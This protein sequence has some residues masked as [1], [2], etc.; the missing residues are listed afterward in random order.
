MKR[1][2]LEWHE[3][4]SDLLLLLGHGTGFCK[5]VW[6]PVVTCLQKQAVGATA[7]AWDA[8]GH[9]SARTL[10]TPIDWWTFGR[11]LAVLVDRLPLQGPVVGVGH[12]MGGTTI[13]M[14]DL[15]RPGLQAGMVLVEPVIFPPPYQRYEDFPLALRTARRRSL[16]PSLEAA[17]ASYRSKPLFR[18]WHPQAFDGYLEGGF[19]EHGA[20]GVTLACPPDVEAAVFAASTD[21]R[22]FDRLDELHSPARLMITDGP[23]DLEGPIKALEGRIAN[24]TTSYLTGEN[25][26]VVMENPDRVAGEIA[27]FLH[28][29]SLA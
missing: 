19:R 8:G 29:L 3:G 22:V 11:E 24:S 25:H 4:S 18:N 15:L 16:F 27:Q 26:L 2:D 1:P 13:I 5:E 9:G 10:D 17:A 7:L 28:S 20:G 23:G 6:R 14:L 21:T 12:S